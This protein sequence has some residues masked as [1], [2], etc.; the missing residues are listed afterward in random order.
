[1]MASKNHT[2]TLRKQPDTLKTKNGQELSCRFDVPFLS[3]LQETARH[4]KSIAIDADVLGGAPRIVG[5]RIPV[6]MILDAI[7][8]YGDLS[9]ALKSYPQLS[10]EQIKEAVGFTREVLERPIDF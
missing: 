5:T 8:F 9:G 7:G 2:E 6:Y 3:V 4:Y 1:M 10:L